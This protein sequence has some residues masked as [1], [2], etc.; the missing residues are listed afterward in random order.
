MATITLYADRINRMPAGLRSVRTAV[1]AFRENVDTLRISV[2][3]IDS[4]IC[5][6][7]QLSQS[8]LGHSGD[9]SGYLRGYRR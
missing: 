8:F 7:H 4:S 3:A 1:D 5:K 6:H 2:V 9:E